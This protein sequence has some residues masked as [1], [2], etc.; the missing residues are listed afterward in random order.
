[1]A[2]RCS[3]GGSRC[4]VLPEPSCT[5]RARSAFLPRLTPRSGICRRGRS[6]PAAEHALCIGDGHAQHKNSATNRLLAD[7]VE[8]WGI[9][10]A[11]TLLLDRDSVLQGVDLLHVFLVLRIGQNPD[12]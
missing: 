6:A 11:G 2:S 3:R 1:M 5:R 8:I 10:V 7:R 12:Y 9:V 4:F